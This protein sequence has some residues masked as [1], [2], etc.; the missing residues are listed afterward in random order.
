MPRVW[1]IT[2]KWIIYF[3]H[4]ILTADTRHSS[5]C[6]F[7]VTGLITPN[8]TPFIYLPFRIKVSASSTTSEL[9]PFEIYKMPRLVSDLFRHVVAKWKNLMGSSV[10]TT[11]ETEIEQEAGT[12]WDNDTNSDREASTEQEMGT[13]WD[14][15]AAPLPDEDEVSRET[16]RRDSGYASV[17]DTPSKPLGEDHF[18]T[19]SPSET[20]YSQL[21]FK[22]KHYFL[23]Y[24]QTILEATC[25]RYARENLSEFLGNPEWK[26]LN[27]LFPSKEYADDRLAHRDWLAEDEIELESWM[28]MFACCVRMPKS[29]R[30]FES[31]MDL[32]N[33]AVHR[34]DR[35]ELG[36]TELSYAMAFPALLGD[37]KA[38]SDITNAFRFVMD[39]PTLDQ[40][41][42]AAVEEAMFTPQPCT[43]HYQVLSRIQTLLEQTCFTTA[44]RTIPHVLSANGWA[45]P[46]QVELQSWQTAF[47]RAAVQ[48]AEPA[49][50]V[51][52]PGILHPRSLGDLLW[53]AR[54]GIRIVAAH[55]LPLSTDGLV[56]QVHAAIAICVLQ[57][58][59]H[60]ALEIEVLAEM[61]VTKRSRAQVL[62]RLGSVWRSGGVGGP[63]E[64]RRRVEIAGFLE[65]EE[66]RVIRE[67]EALVVSDTFD[68]GW[69]DLE[70][71]WAERMWSPSMHECLK[72]VEV[73]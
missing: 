22:T 21:P 61:Y 60:R 53:R 6:N 25:L 31:V 71:P 59:W 30:I 68:V 37:K 10:S 34:G 28:Q 42:K 24:I 1:L 67:G 19:T 2:R 16:N 44:A 54:F 14:S 58:D 52:P 26:K 51:F 33:A 55:R 57:D 9:A 48:H 70:V 40:A 41:T 35:E 73:W 66:G 49:S 47:Q 5:S 12:G 8:T 18:S 63:Y 23:T 3:F 46:E 45:I 4:I 20:K 29:K 27:L 13:G 11:W 17:G 36:F 62:E 72:R 43:T 7:S 39:D 50:D 32:R 56:A 15:H 64:W 38:E 65:R 69:W